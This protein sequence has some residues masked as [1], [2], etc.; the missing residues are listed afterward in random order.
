MNNDLLI[1]IYSFSFHNQKVKLFDPA[2][3]GGGFVF[4]CRALP[5]PHRIEE[6]RNLT[7]LD[8][9]V[10]NYMNQFQETHH[11]LNHSQSLVL[12]TIENYQKRGFSNLQIAFG[13]TGG[14]HR[15]VYCADWLEKALLQKGFST[16][17][18]HWELEQSEKKYQKR[19]GMILAAGFGTRLLPMTST[20]PK[21][22]IKVNGKTMLDWT[23]EALIA[24]GCSEITINTHHHR[25]QI[26]DWWLQAQK[27]FPDVKITLSEE[28]EILGTAG[29]IKKALPY[30]HSPNPVIIHN[31]DI[32]T[33]YPLSNLYQM[34]ETQ[35][36]DSIY[37]I[38]LGSKRVSS[39]YFL[40]NNQN[41]ICGIS[42]KENERILKASNDILRKIA[43][44]GIHFLYPKAMEEIS[45]SNKFNII[46]VYMDWVEKGKKLKVY[47]VEGNW[48]DMGSAEKLKNLQDFFE[49]R[50]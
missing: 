8:E 19:R 4:D 43:F 25:N 28:I 46:D 22:L 13:C 26:Y 50:K 48:Y 42:V 15:S 27:C 37:C 44:S 40:V 21:A 30:L 33:D 45:N 23:M 39:S 14:R 36:D 10:Q 7:G 2:G 29:G 49:A 41:E 3:N 38:L 6:L 35:E 47:E 9:S 20:I 11:F 32:W 18:I 31:C 17:V 1:R 12:Q 34:V 16:K 5:N 24:C